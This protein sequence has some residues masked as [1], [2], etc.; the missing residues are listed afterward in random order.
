MG[1]QH[2]IKIEPETVTALVVSFGRSIWLRRCVESLIGAAKNEE[3]CR[4][5]IH[6]AINGQDPEGWNTA[7]ALQSEFSFYVKIVDR[8][9]Q[10]VTPAEARNR[11]L[12]RTQNKWILFI[13]D[14]AYVE[15]DYF[16]RF[17][18]AQVTFPN[19]SA[20]GGPNITP[21]NSTV[22]QKSCGEALA[23]RFA[24]YTSFSRYRP[25]GRPRV[26]D[27]RELISCNLIVARHSLEDRPFPEHFKSAEENWVMQ[28]LTLRE[29]QMVHVP[30]L[31]AWHERRADWRGFAQQIFKYGYGRGQNIA[32]RP[33]SLRAAYLVPI[34]ACGFALVSIVLGLWS[35]RWHWSFWTLSGI[36]LMASLIAAARRSR[37]VGRVA[38]LFPLIHLSYA[39]GICTGF[40]AELL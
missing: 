34:A 1:R 20:F 12:L 6:L 10:S 15:G 22:F 35:G 13:D 40:F 17:I 11:M 9:E 3:L 5:A 37:R 26:V 24:N 7:L 27:E 14:D 36:Y 4:L 18:E 21:A 28:T 33:R 39:C 2:Q 30:T 16:T 32:R 29:H 38:I 31:K 23:S 8:Y 19:A 25:R